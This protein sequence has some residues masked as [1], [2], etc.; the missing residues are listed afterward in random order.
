MWQRIASQ[1]SFWFEASTLACHRV[2]EDSATS[3]MRLDAA[4]VREVRET[5]DFTTTYHSSARGRMLARKARFWYANVAVINAREVLVEAGFRPAWKQILGALRL[6][7]SP[8]VV[9]NVC[10][11]FILW[12]RIVA[13][14]LKHGLMLNPRS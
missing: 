4:D 8:R 9:W 12:L 7:H 2:H 14:R 11:F 3:R 6:C 13:S 5:I 10:W 1:F